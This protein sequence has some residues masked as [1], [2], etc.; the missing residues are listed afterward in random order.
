VLDAQD[1]D[2]AGQG[3]ESDPPISLT[4]AEEAVSRAE[5]RAE[6][7]RARAEQLRRQA[8]ATSPHESDPDD[9]TDVE[10][11]AADGD[12]NETAESR[13]SLARLRRSLRG[14][15]SRVRPPKQSTVGVGAAIILCAASLGASGYMLWQ[16]ISL[17]HEH[18][19]AAEFT[20]AARAGVE[21]MMSIDPDHA[22]EN[23]QRLIDNTTGTMQT[24]LRATSTLL[25]EDAQKA[26]VTTKA[27]AEDTAVESMTD[28]SA[29]VL[30]LAKS[31]TTNPDKSKR[32]PAYWRLSVG[33]TRDGGQLKMSKV[34]FVE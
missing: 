7:A 2:D 28:N 19:R 32:P 18:K 23:V 4:E 6:E 8:A 20:T 29:V 9:A 21:L 11:T 25:V 5:A 10:D 24:Q 30:V 1:S 15:Q 17:M 3:V 22:R 13:P 16:H 12:D 33:L 26:K 31:D 27:T 14:L 34:D